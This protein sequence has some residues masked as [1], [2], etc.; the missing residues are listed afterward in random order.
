VSSD[1]RRARASTRR[2]LAAL[3]PP[4][5]PAVLVLGGL[6]A[7]VRSG[8]LPSFLVPA[9]SAVARSLVSDASELYP[10]LFQTASAALLGFAISALAGS[11]A[12]IVLSSSRAVQRAVY[13]YAVFSQTVPL[14]AIA[15]LLV[16]WFGWDRTALASAIIVSIFPVIA[17]TLSGLR[18]T[19]PALLDLFQLYRASAWDSLFKLRLPAAMPQIFTG[20]RVSGGLAVIGAVVGEFITGQGIGGAISVARQLQRV[21]LIFAGVLLASVLGLVLFGGVNLAAWLVLRRWHASES[22]S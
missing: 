21:D 15:P 22:R 18:S 11:V 3:L 17:N 8:A 10:A 5:V 13:P 1:Q 19:E 20:L 9:P 4:L 12:A 2:A 14:V 6:E 7:L 16:I